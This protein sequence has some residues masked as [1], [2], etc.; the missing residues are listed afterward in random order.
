MHLPTRS[1]NIRKLHPSKASLQRRAPASEGMRRSCMAKGAG[2]KGS[3]GLKKLPEDVKKEQGASQTAPLKAAR[4]SFKALFIKA[5]VALSVLMLAAGAY[6]W[7]TLEEI[8]SYVVPKREQAYPLESGMGA[9]DVV[10]ELTDGEFPDFLLSLWLRVHRGEFDAIQKGAYAVD[11]T[12]TLTEILEDMKEGNVLEIEPLRLLLLEGE[13]LPLMLKRFETAHSLDNDSAQCLADP[14][15]FI[16]DHLPEGMETLYGTASSLEGLFMPATYPYFEGGSACA[17]LEDA[18]TSMA[19]FLSAAWEKRA[20][21]IALKSPYEALILASIVERESS[22]N[23]ERALIARVFYN[24][25]EDGMRLQTDASVMYGVSPAF[26]GILKRSQLT[27]DTPYNTYTRDG[28]PPTPIAMPSAGSIEAVLHPGNT[29]ALFFV[30]KSHDP[31]DG[32]VF[33]TTL[34]NHTRAVKDY[35]RKVREYRQSLKE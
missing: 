15:A 31:R 9:R 2:E 4:S 6:L 19:A 33:S 18:F 10:R 22:L 21:G 32:H 12:K 13:S 27:K 7:I 24:R 28:L 16:R 35:R 29:S 30:A 17:I 14:A 23:S 26:R 5:A 3:P 25:L 1:K 8:G 11:G 20:P 34:R